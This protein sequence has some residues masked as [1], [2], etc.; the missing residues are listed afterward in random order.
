MDTKIQEAL[1]RDR[2]V[3]ITTT[4][5]GTGRA[6]RIEIW[7][8]YLEGRL[9]LTGL[10]GRRSWYANLRANPQLIVHLKQSIRADLAA[11]ATPVLE[12]SKRREIMSL[13]LRRLGRL[14]DLDAWVEGSPLV[15]VVLETRAVRR[16]SP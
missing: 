15:E 14:A 2:V 12:A 4:G 8:H 11:T 7:V 13:I 9:Y 16:G 1:E 5:R 6:R 3:D 10:P